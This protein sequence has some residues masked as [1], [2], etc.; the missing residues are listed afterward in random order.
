M[1]ENPFLAKIIKNN[2]SL[3]IT[4]PM[5][6]IVKPLGLKKDDYVRISNIEKIEV[7]KE[8]KK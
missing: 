4:I 3:Q 2:D 1:T 6:Q 5:K 8:D 7:R